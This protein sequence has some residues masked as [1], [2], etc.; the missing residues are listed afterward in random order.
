MI[1]RACMKMATKH[2]DASVCRSLCTRIRVREAW[3]MRYKGY[4]YYYV[5][6][7]WP[8]PRRRLAF[9]FRYWIGEMASR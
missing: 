5:V 1:C 8:K 4:Y 6:A 9:F 7:P 3:V 2:D